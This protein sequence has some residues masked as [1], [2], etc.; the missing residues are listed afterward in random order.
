MTGI[1]TMERFIHGKAKFVSQMTGNS[2][3]HIPSRKPER[4]CPDVEMLNVL[5][6]ARILGSK[7]W[8]GSQ[9][10]S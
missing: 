9:V 8:G 5:N 10:G 2:T 3:S 7:R 1:Q 4:M 6:L